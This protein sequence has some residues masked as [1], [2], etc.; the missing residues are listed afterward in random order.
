LAW[1]TSDA[2]VFG[3]FIIAVVALF[4]GQAEA[5]STWLALV[6]AGSITVLQIIIAIL[7]KVLIALVIGYAVRKVIDAVGPEIAIGIAL[8]AA[9]YSVYS[10]F[11]AEGFGSNMCS[12]PL[13]FAEHLLTISSGLVDG[14]NNAFAGKIQDI[15]NEFSNLNAESIRVSALIT[16]TQDLLDTTTL[17][18]PL[19]IIGEEPDA[20]YRRTMFSGNVGVAAIDGVNNYVERALTLPTIAMTLSGTEVLA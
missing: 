4:F 7:T 5:L 6:A 20:Y 17:L 9:A 13:P 18:S 1:Y 11:G 16:T 12:A 10:G 8:L 19:T 2:V 14:V 3:L 15:Q